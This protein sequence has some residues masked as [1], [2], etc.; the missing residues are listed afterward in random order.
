MKISLIPDDPSL[1]PIVAWDGSTPN[2]IGQDDSQFEIALDRYSTSGWYESPEVNESTIER[3][4]DDGDYWPSRL[5]LKKR[6]VTIRAHIVQHAESSTVELSRF[7]DLCNAL[8]GQRLT[9][10]VEDPSGRR[11]AGCYLSSS[12]T[13]KSNLGFTN[14]TLIVTCPDPLKYGEPMSFPEVYGLIRYRNEGTAATW[15]RFDVS[16]HVTSLMLSSGESKVKW[17]GDA[18]NLSIDFRDMIP[19]SGRITADQAFRIP[20]GSGEIRI[21]SSP[22]A[23]VTMTIRPAWR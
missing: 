7:N 6:V 17:E 12:T 18:D 19:S 5:T 15:P 13:W 3:P 16:G 2:R 23:T 4:Q 8:A 21:T 10:M 20:P 9:L 22:S 11:T 14:L 1:L